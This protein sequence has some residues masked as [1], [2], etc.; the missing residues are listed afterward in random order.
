MHQIWPCPLNLSLVSYQVAVQGCHKDALSAAFC[1]KE[2][3][4]KGEHGQL[5]MT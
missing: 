3:K 4:G 1:Q 2:V 5:R